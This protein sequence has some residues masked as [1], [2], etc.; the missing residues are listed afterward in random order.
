MVFRKVAQWEICLCREVNLKVRRAICLHDFTVQA[1][2]SHSLCLTWIKVV[3]RDGRRLAHLLGRVVRPL[4]L[5]RHGARRAGERARSVPRPH[6][7]VTRPRISLALELLTH[8]T[9]APDSPSRRQAAKVKMVGYITLNS[10]HS[11]AAQEK[12]RH[13]A[14]TSVVNIVCAFLLEEIQRKIQV[15]GLTS[16]NAP[17]ARAGAT[18]KDQKAGFIFF[19]EPNAPGLCRKNLGF[20]TPQ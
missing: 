9:P 7:L 19:K 8:P 14:C 17:R 16:H 10:R 12:W 20:F 1:P 11:T 15:C 4:L 2:A 18:N 13:F 5:L 3:R 6:G